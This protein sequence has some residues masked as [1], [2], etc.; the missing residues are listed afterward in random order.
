MKILGISCS[1][2]PGGNTETML[3]ASLG[4]AQEAG[5]GTEL[6]TLA[7]KT[8]TPCDGCLSCRKTGDC[9]IK[10]DMQDIY[11]L[12]FAA[13]GIIIGTPVYFWSVAAQ[14]KALIDRTF[15]VTPQRN[16]KNKAAGAV[17]AVGRDGSSGAL[18][19][20][21]SF[22]TGHRMIIIGSAVGVANEKG[23]VKQ[24][25]TGMAGAEGLGRA[26]TRYLKTG[27]M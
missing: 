9:H 21:N 23:A 2:R 24:D 4:T 26:M 13:D 19:V 27:K 12:L 6:V 15:M 5:V 14:T 17:V 10:D 3:R 18:A 8:I 7:G 11:P 25:K 22:F 16:L 20:L 1:P